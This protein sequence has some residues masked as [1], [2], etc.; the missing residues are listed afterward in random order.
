MKW[1]RHESRAHRDAKLQKLVMRY[2][3]EGYGMYWYCVENICDSIEPRLTFE[4]EADSEILAH[5]GRI[6][7]RRV[8]EI[9]RY[10]VHLDLFEQADDLITCLKLARYLGE[11]STRNQELIGLIKDAKSR[12]VPDS[13]RQSPTVRLCPPEIREDKIRKREGAKRP[14]FAPPTL[15]NVTDRITEKGYRHVDPET[16]WHFY[17]SKGWVVG[18]AKM[19]S[20]ESALAQWEAR[21]KSE[22]KQN[23]GEPAV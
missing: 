13:P 5:V 3:F 16:F 10:M 21:A 9:M 17:E 20:W 7:S 22:V 1:F 2:G 4:L 11:K 19:R 6:D 8:E 18:K 14:R 12:T 15:Q 23:D